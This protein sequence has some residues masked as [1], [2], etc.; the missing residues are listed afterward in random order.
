VIRDQRK[1][2]KRFEDLIKGHSFRVSKMERIRE[3]N[4]EKRAENGETREQATRN[5]TGT[6]DDWPWTMRY[7]FGG[8]K[9]K[10][11]WEENV[12]RKP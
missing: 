9:E 11:I 5:Q 6:M 4:R 3:E 2:K 10:Q 7:S 1:M 8:T 12:I